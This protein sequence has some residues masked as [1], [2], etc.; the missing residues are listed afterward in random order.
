MAEYIVSNDSLI[1]HTLAPPDVPYLR[2]AGFGNTVSLKDFVFD[3]SLTMSFVECW[4]P[5]IHRFHLSWGECI[6][7]LQ[8]V[9]YHLELCAHGKPIGDASMISIDATIPRLGSW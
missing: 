5:E 2:E 6:I 3:N 7:T 4:R 8:D 9:A 1:S